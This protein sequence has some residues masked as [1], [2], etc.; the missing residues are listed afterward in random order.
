MEAERDGRRLHRLFIEAV[1]SAYD[2]FQAFVTDEKR[3]F[4]LLFFRAL[5]INETLFDNA[6]RFEL[7]ES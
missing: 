4:R 5:H 7:I 3:Y 1:Q 6:T 2:E